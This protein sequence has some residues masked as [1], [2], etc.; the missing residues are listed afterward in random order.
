MGLCGND[1][2]FLFNDHDE[3]AD[4]IALKRA[5]AVE[6]AE[7]HHSQRPDIGFDG[8]CFSL[9]NLRSHVDGRAKHSLRDFILVLK[10]LAEAEICQLDDAVVQQQVFRF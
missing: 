8:I 1:D 4:V 7:K 2:V 3:F 5:E 6:H 10:W 9:Q